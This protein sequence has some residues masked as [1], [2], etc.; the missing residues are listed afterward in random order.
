MKYLKELLVPSIPV[1]IACILVVITRKYKIVG[2]IVYTIAIISLILTISL[3]I[4]HKIKN[5]K[6][7]KK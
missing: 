1:V 5:K 4:Y 3:F 7:K 6:N 2:Y